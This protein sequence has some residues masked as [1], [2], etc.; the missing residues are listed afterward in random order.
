M[1]VRAAIDS[2]ERARGYADG[3]SGTVAV[4]ATATV[5]NA[6]PISVSIPRI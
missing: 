2:G 6:D 1:T 3:I 4:Y 5:L